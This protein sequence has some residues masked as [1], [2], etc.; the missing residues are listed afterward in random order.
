MSQEGFDLLNRAAAAGAIVIYPEE[1][2]V[3]LKFLADVQDDKRSYN[4][5]VV[6]A[7]T[8]RCQPVREYVRDRQ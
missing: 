8:R 4:G 6:A 7:R 1:R 5:P 3:A 2:D